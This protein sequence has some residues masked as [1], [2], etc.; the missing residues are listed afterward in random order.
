MFEKNDLVSLD[1]NKEYLIIDIVDIEQQKYI[2]LMDIND[3]KNFIV[4]L[5]NE[6]N[7]VLELTDQNMIEKVFDAIKKK[8]NL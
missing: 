3:N 7:Q 5:L 2:Y 4:G 6:K 8:N 1:D